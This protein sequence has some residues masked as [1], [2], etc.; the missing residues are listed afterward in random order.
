MRQRAWTT[1]RTARGALMVAGVCGVAL[2]TACG[3]A[4][5]GSPTAS[6]SDTSATTTATAAPTRTSAAPA[7][8]LEVS[9]KA[10]QN[11]C[12]MLEPELSNWRVQGPTIGRIGLNLMAHEWALTNG[13]GNTQLLG[14]TAVVDRATSAT[15]PDVRTQALEA[16][17]LPELAAG[18][19]TL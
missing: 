18:V 11:L 19:L 17:E 4:Q 1:V 12:D 15:C 10:A 8:P 3:G 5:T 9:D 6:P 14:D 7:T 2:L 16:L 13:V